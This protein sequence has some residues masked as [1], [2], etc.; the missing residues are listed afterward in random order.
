MS[1]GRRLLPS[2]LSLFLICCIAG[3]AAADELDCTVDINLSAL[4]EQDRP[5]WETFKQDVQA[6]INN[7]SWTTNFSGERIRCSMQLNITNSNGAYAAQL[8]VT[9][10]R[11]LYKSEQVTT[12]ARFFDDKIQFNYS[13]GQVL[14]HSSSYR[15]LESVIDYYCYVIL[16]LDYD[17]YK[18]QSGTPYFQQAN[19]IAVVGLA[20]NGTGW[21]K[22]FSVSGNY[23]RASYIEDVLNASNRGFRDIYWDYNYNV[24]DLL[25]TKSDDARTELAIILDTLISLKKTSSAY[26]RS[27]FMRT[28]F[29]ARYPELA[30]LGR[31]YPQ[32]LDV[33]YQKLV[34]LD[35]L[36]QTYYQDS[37]AKFEQ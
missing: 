37:K 17:S 27:S 18:A 20:A 10:S 32:N 1:F 9:S 12:M 4:P 22:N 2:L 35:P 14:Q 7:Y 28:F 16:G 8:F 24:L 31:L 15:P 33:Y 26:Q 5:I 23:S 6:Y 11:P 25:S 3:P 21:E 34:F 13:R 36:H 19:Q 29:E 30:D